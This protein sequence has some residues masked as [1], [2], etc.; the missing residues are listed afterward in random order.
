MPILIIIF[1]ILKTQ[2]YMILQSLYQQNAIKN[3][4]NFV[5][6][7]LKDQCIGTNIK[8]KTRIK[9]QQMSLDI[10]LNQNL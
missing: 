4:Q 6:K 8:Q 5:A 10:F 1:L 9:I 3:Y 7:G 2:N